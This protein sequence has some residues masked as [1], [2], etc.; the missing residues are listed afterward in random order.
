MRLLRAGMLSAEPQ[1]FEMDLLPEEDQ[2]MGGRSM[3]NSEQ[4]F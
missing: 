4:I 2:L 3:N 1:P